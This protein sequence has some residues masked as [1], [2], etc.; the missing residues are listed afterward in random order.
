[1]KV[2]IHFARVLTYNKSFTCDAGIPECLRGKF[3]ELFHM[4]FQCFRRSR[5]QNSGTSFF[6]N[7]YILGD[8]EFWLDAG[9]Y[10][11]FRGL[12]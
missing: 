9:L 3:V 4:I 12:L 1:M 2:I 6:S 10:V 5:R 8:K 7:K 11:Y